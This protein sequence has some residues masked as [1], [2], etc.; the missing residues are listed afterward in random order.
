[1]G[2]HRA[3][4]S[5][6]KLTVVAPSAW[7]ADQARSSRVFSGRQV[8]VIPNPIDNAF[9]NSKISKINAR[10]EIGCGTDEVIGVVIAENLLDPVKRVEEIVREFSRVSDSS[11][12]PLRLLLVGREGRAFARTRPDVLALGSLGRDEVIKV[13]C[14]ADFLISGSIAESAGL[15]ISE[16]GALGVPS[17]VASG[18]GS[19]N[20][21]IPKKSGL[22]FS[23]LD[24][25]GEQIMRVTNNH[26]L[27]LSLGAQAKLVSEG[28][29]ASVVAGKYQ[30][31]YNDLL[32]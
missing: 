21:L 13:L 20:Q 23:S 26:D 25:L 32:D 4:A 19:E 27:L 30:T 24:E 2:A 12:N 31:I 3:V 18:S 28:H 5:L 7:L 22:V 14:A 15:T 9:F 8:E 1:M 29:K 6:Q 11:T 17:L 16:A 10:L